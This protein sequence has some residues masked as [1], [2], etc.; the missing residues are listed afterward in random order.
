MVL[1]ANLELQELLAVRAVV[2]LLVSATLEEPVELLAELPAEL[3]APVRP[4]V[5]FAL[6][7]QFPMAPT[8]L[9]L[10]SFQAL[11]QLQG[12]L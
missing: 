7:L 1:Q 6:G 3:L 9:G 2:V 11:L 8:T 10:Q 4:T 12:S 5:Y